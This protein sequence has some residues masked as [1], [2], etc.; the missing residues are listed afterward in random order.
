MYVQVK[1]T[2]FTINGQTSTMVQ[3]DDIS[4]RILYDNQ[5]AENNFLSL[6]NACV[7][8][9]MRNPLNAMI[10]YNIEKAALYQQL[11]EMRDRLPEES[12]E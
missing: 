8:H 2:E 12:K 1:L 4:T 7:S 9:E 5:K 6:T 10:A 3:I 11:R